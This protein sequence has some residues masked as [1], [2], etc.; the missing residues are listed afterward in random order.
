[1]NSTAEHHRA[2]QEFAHSGP[3]ASGW[4]SAPE[5]AW[6]NEGGHLL[7]GPPDGAA[8]CAGRG[9]AIDEFRASPMS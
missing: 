9:V 5:L 2:D 3:V 8:P 1:M 4:T 6:E 7:P